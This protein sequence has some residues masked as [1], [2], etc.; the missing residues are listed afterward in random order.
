[1][2][3]SIK[4]SI[5]DR[6]I[7]ESDRSITISK[8]TIIAITK[9]QFINRTSS[10]SVSTSDAQRGHGNPTA[11]KLDAINAIK[12]NSRTFGPNSHIIELVIADVAEPDIRSFGVTKQTVRAI[13]PYA[14]Y[15]WEF[16]CDPR[17]VKLYA[18]DVIK[19]IIRAS[20]ALSDVIKSII[21][22]LDDGHAVIRL[23]KRVA[24]TSDS[25][26]VKLDAAVFRCD[27]SAVKLNA[28]DAIKPIVKPVSNA[29]TPHP[30]P[31][32]S[33]GNSPDFNAA[34]AIKPIARTDPNSVDEWAFSAFE[35]IF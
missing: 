14:V 19:S 26:E 33:R 27:S 22:T 32:K 24:S 31:T 4:T 35:I 11:V 34:N 7:L 25:T 6:S 16:G 13:N 8:S 9:H 3:G 28:P 1:M 30:H 20:S 23:I 29:T 10:I 18:L 21:R 5:I 15:E 2:L 12:S 17:A